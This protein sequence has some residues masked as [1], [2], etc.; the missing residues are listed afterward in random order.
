MCSSAHYTLFRAAPSPDEGDEANVEYYGSLRL[1]SESARATAKRRGGLAWA[2]RFLERCARE[3]RGEARLPPASLQDLITRCNYFI[4]RLKDAT[5][6]HE[7][8]GHKAKGKAKAKPKPSVEPNFANLEQALEA[9]QGCTKCL[10]AK[11]GSKG[12]RAC[13]CEWFEHLRQRR[14]DH[15]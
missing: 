8:A 11:F 2:A 14:A 3:D 1:S 15:E 13:M 7:E 5:A 4:K 6:A 12:C 9:A 10:P